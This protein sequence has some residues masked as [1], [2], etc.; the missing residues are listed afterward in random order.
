MLVLILL[1]KSSRP[2]LFNT[3]EGILRI[4]LFLHS[5]VPVRR[6]FLLLS[7]PYLCP[8]SDIDMS[9]SSFLRFIVHNDSFLNISNIDQRF[10]IFE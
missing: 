8:S 4:T 10:P 7:N 5:T 9:I 2:L 1:V 3:L 6:S